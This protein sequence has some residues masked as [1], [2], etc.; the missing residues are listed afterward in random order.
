MDQ[1][2]VLRVQA[3]RHHEDGPDHV[4]HGV[5]SEVSCKKH[6]PQ[7]PLRENKATARQQPG[8][9]GDPVRPSPAPLTECNERRDD[10]HRQGGHEQVDGAGQA[11]DLP[12]AGVA[13]PDHVGVSVVH[14]DVTLNADARREGAADLRRTQGQTGPCSPNMHTTEHRRSTRNHRGDRQHPGFIVCVC[15][16]FVS[17]SSR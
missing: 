7:D 14:L 9:P 16:L 15:V 2:P 3:Q 1:Q 11:G 6:K 4:G 8:A 17:T 10:G 13:Q 5:T 12:H